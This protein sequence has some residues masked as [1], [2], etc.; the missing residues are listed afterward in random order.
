L[1]AKYFRSL[2]L[3]RW[4]KQESI[5]KKTLLPDQT[6]FYINLKRFL[7]KDSNYLNKTFSKSFSG[8][9]SET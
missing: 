3:E 6:L 4:F 8:K 7:I 9:N 2:A 5:F 1:A